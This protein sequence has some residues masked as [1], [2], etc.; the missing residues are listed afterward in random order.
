MHCDITVGSPVR[1]KSDQQKMMVAT[2]ENGVATC[3]WIDA[4]GHPQRQTFPST[5]LELVPPERN[6]WGSGKVIRGS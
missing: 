4:S 6:A 3:D 1:L 2:M 5:S